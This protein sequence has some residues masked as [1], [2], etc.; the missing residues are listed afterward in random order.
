MPFDTNSLLFAEKLLAARRDEPTPW[1]VWHSASGERIELSGRVFDNWVSKSAH[2]LNELFDVHHGSQIVMDLPTH[3]KSL[4]I[5]LAAFQSGACVLSPGHPQ[6]ATADLWVSDNPA[7]DHIPAS[8]DVLAVDLAALSLQFS[9][10]LGPA[11]DYNANVRTF[12]DDYFPEPVT[13]TQPA[14]ATEHRTLSYTELFTPAN[15][16][17]GTIL[18]SAELSL[19]EVLRF[20]IAQWF[21]GDALV[22][23]GAEVQVT[24]RLL[25]GERVS[26]RYPTQ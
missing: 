11:E 4:V 8:A 23:L 14:L 16:A 3:W 10:D 26:A 22:L 13:G 17:Q 19:D 15:S 1:L 9:G 20:A 5:S 6:A 18:I 12:A 21:R 24:D 7:G 2:L 25:S